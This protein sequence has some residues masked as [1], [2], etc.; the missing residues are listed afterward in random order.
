[1][2]APRIP[3]ATRVSSYDSVRSANSTASVGS[4]RSRKSAL[5]C[6]DTVASTVRDAEDITEA[7]DCAVSVD[8]SASSSMDLSHGTISS[9]DDYADPHRSSRRRVYGK[10]VLS[11]GNHNHRSGISAEHSRD[12]AQHDPST[13]PEEVTS[14]VEEEEEE[15]QL[16]HDHESAVL[17][18][19]RGFA[20]SQ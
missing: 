3:T 7:S 10:G 20:L 13:I 17:V 11:D 9:S 8:R 14:N 16:D 15:S 2:L 12:L 6:G 19:A 18:L 5:G 1:M 4:K